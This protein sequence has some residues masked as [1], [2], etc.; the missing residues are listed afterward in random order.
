MHMGRSGFVT[1]VSIIAGVLAGCGDLGSG[2]IAA[3]IEVQSSGLTAAQRLA[4]CAQDPRVVTGL[5]S[6]QVCAGADIFFRETFDGNGRNVRHLPPGRE[7]H[8]HRAARSSATCTPP[9]RPIRCSCSRPTRRSPTSR[10]RAGLFGNGV[11][12]RERRRLRGPDAQVRAALGAARAVD[13]DQHRARPGR[14]RHHQPAR[15]A[16]RLGRRRRARRR[17]AAPVPDRRHHPALH[18]EPAAAVRGTDFRAADRAGAGSD[19][20][21]PAARSAALN[22]LNLQQVNLF[23]AEANLGRQAFMDPPRGR[24]NVCHLN[25]GANFD[26]TRARTATSTPGPGS[27]PAGNVGHLRRRP[28]LRRR[29]R[30]PGARAPELRRRIDARVPRTRSATARST[31]RRSSR[32]PTPRP[33]FHN[34]Q[35]GAGDRGRGR[36]STSGL[37]PDSPAGAGAGRALRQPP[38]NF[39]NEDG[40]AIGRFLR[41]LNVA[42]NLDI[43]KQRRARRADAVQ[44]LPRHAQGHPDQA[45]AA[46][47]DRDRRR[48]RAC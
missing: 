46:G 38:I 35:F 10:I 29:L 33:F 5:V 31:R 44:P 2:D 25:A 43:A 45:A 9:T 28:L 1:L 6:A 12:P 37:F 23:D 21:V 15:R 39:T 17:L 7:Q 40:F 3:D 42:F 32:R 13:E 34:N 14:R 19:Q 8:H 20:H 36:S 26:L 47:R 11:D 18:E 48:A 16:H 22:E 27:P 4:A 24:C 30:R 41:A